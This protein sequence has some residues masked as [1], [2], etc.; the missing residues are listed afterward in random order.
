MTYDLALIPGDGIGRE[1]LPQG[2]RVLEALARRF[3]FELRFKEY[4]FSSSY[5]LEHGE[6][7]PEHAFAELRR[8]HAIFLG[9]IGD[10]RRVPDHISLRGLLIPLR[11]RFDLYVNLRPAAALPGL[12][13]PLKGDPPFD[14]LFIRENSEGEYAGAGGRLRQGTPEEIALQTSIFTRKGVERVVRYA[15]ERARQRRRRLASATKSNAMQYTFVLWDEVVEELASE[16]PEIEVERYHADA[17]AAALVRNPGHFD[18]VVASNLLG[19]ILTD[20]A[21]ALQGSLGVPASANLNPERKFPSLF[22]PV[23]GSAPDIAGQGIANP[24]ATFWAAALLL[25]FLGQD[26]AAQHLMQGMH[27]L[28]QEARVLTP[29]LGGSARTEDVTEALL[30]YI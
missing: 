9:A 27:R 12:P 8:H 14:I 28:T 18:V 7:M 5:Y 13:G 25:E 4:P 6:M 17:L 19:D 11:Q 16:Y 15:F 21:G 23:H 3:G 29:D 24:L 22:E 30:E 1:V 10:P 26:E 20:L 2:V